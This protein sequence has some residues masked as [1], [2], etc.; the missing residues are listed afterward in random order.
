VSI[1]T[2]RVQTIH[3][4]SGLIVPASLIPSFSLRHG[5]TCRFLQPLLRHSSTV[6]TRGAHESEWPAVPAI[7]NIDDIIG[8]D[9]L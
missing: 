7:R 8:I 9:R 4:Q 5:T 6:V 2:I 1:Q 3:A